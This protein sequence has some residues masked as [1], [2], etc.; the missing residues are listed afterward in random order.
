MSNTFM[1]R[2]VQ[3]HKQPHAQ[4]QS[5]SFSVTTTFPGCY[6]VHEIAGKQVHIVFDKG[7]LLDF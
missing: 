3:V 1:L 5:K 6:Q 7:I 4:K 2:A